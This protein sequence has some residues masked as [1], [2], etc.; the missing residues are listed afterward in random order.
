VPKL[1]QIPHNK[2]TS[3]PSVIEPIKQQILQPAPQ[4]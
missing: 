1:Q 3:V 2:F 4:I